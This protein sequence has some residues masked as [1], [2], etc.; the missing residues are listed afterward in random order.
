[1]FFRDF[2]VFFFQFLQK[3]NSKFFAFVGK[4][5]TKNDNKITGVS[6]LSSK[7]LI[8]NWENQKNTRK[9]RNLFFFAK[10]VFEYIFFKP[11]NSK[12][13]RIVVHFLENSFQKTHFFRFSE[14]FVI[15]FENFRFDL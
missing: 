12:K 4:N 14:F 11:E 5:L 6:Q 7:I 10:N 1:M 13:V 2:S 9:L 3:S 8:F 15:V